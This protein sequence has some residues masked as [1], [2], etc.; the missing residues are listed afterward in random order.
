MN[1]HYMEHSSSFSNVAS[2]GKL[3]FAS[4]IK[5]PSFASCCH[6]LITS[7]S[8]QELEIICY[9]WSPWWFTNFGSSGANMEP[10]KR[11][12][13]QNGTSQEL[14]QESTPSQHSFISTNSLQITLAPCCTLVSF[15]RR[16]HILWT[17]L[18][19]PTKSVVS[20]VVHIGPTTKQA[21]ISKNSLGLFDVDVTEHN[22][23]ISW[24]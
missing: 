16:Q 11:A 8:S 4:P 3:R 22:N 9:N 6:F 15:E 7:E 17:A 12:K 21:F 24:E 5:M 1:N 20:H 14:W 13:H 18:A 23:R 2:S 10:Q 19:R